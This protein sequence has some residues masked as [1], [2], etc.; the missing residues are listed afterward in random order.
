[1]ALSKRIIS[2]ANV[3]FPVRSSLVVS[4]ARAPSGELRT[5]ESETG[6]QQ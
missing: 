3:E 5:P 1:M 6:G 2:G 4:E